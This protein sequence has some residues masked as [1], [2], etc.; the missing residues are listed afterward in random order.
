VYPRQYADSFWSAE[1]RDDVFVAMSFD[2]DLQI[3]YTQAIEPACS[4]D[5]ALK[6]VRIDLETGGDSIITRILDGLTHS[7][8]VVAEISTRRQG[9]QKSRNGNVMWEVGVAHAFR[10]FDEVIL[11][12]SDQDN[13]LFDIGPIRVHQYPRYDLQ[14]ARTTVATLIKDRLTAIDLTKS[15]LVERALRALDPNSL[16]MLLT[17]VPM[18]GGTFDLHLPLFPQQMMVKLFDLGI[19]AFAYDA[20]TLETVERARSTKDVSPLQKY[21][22]T[23]FGKVVLR[24]ILG[25]LK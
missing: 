18:T 2:E 6:P 12:R 16:S 15:L 4:E 11:L 8:L 20:I 3:V 19:L 13:L 23:A 14:A 1:I 9:D 10:Q 7:R 22:L 24:K 5:N 17:K 21:R 25:H